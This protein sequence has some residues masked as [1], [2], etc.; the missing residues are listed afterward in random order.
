MLHCTMLQ[1]PATQEDQ[2]L[3]EA[4][5]LVDKLQIYRL[6]MEIVLDTSDRDCLS[7]INYVDC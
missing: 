4:T 5:F 7:A 2:S 3:C 6:V 1:A